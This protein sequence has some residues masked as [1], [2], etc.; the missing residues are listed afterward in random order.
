MK[1]TCQEQEGVYKGT[2]EEAQE[3]GLC[4]TTQ[5][6]K[7]IMSPGVKVVAP[8]TGVQEAAAFMKILDVGSIPVS[9]GHRLIGMIT[10][11]DITVRIVA[12]KRDPATAIVR[13]A[14]TESPAFCFDDQTVQEATGVMEHLQI[15]RL[16]ILNRD[17][18][19]VG[20]VS[21]A[22]LAVRSS[23]PA[24]AKVLQ[25]VSELARA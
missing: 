24:A 3:A 19:L 2:P 21:L 23:L 12:E 9:D 5:S 13:E 20:I 22:D 11:R 4:E 15:R 7:H 8:E 6:L 10:D 25:G 17:N 14:M 18:K 1:E 16:P